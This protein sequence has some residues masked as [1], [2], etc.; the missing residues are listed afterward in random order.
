[1]DV[2]HDHV[3]F[4]Q[5]SKMQLKSM[6]ITE[7]PMFASSFLLVLLNKEKSKEKKK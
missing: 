5:K 1:M 2:T 6:F 4:S 7:V 3:F